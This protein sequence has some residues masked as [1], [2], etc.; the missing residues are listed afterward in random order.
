MNRNALRRIIAAVFL[1][2]LIFLLSC[3]Y[4]ARTEDAKFPP[5]QLGALRIYLFGMIFAA[6]LA[7]FFAGTAY[8]MKKNGMKQETASWFAVLAVPICFVLSRL[9]FCLLS[10]DRILGAQDYG[11]LFRVTE[12]GFLLW[13]ALAGILLTAKITGKITNQSGAKTADSAIVPACLLI[14]ALRLVCGLLFKGFGAGLS[15][16][17]W[18]DPEETDFAYRYSV[19]PL[20]D[21]SFFERF[22]FATLNYYDYWCWAV[23]VLQALWAGITGFLVSRSEAAPGGKTVRFVILFSC[24]T[25]VLESMLY[26]GEIVHLPWL[27]FVKANQILSAVAL[28]TALTVCLRRLPKNIRAKKALIIFPQFLAAIGVIIVMEFAAFEKKI[29]SINWLPSDAC[30]LIMGLACLW[31]ALAFRKAWKQAYT[32]ERPA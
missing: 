11:M 1:F 7:L 32:E 2:L 18:F 6:L 25:I 21:Y 9:G 12:G 17:Y 30:H 14:L 29:T 23:F 16:D 3:P 24:G 26:G 13:G 20:E 10:I 28:L 15:L 8:R 5:I 19:W 31:I 27:G 22:P 4:I